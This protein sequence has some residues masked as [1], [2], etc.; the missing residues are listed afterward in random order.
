MSWQSLPL[1][2]TPTATGDTAASPE[3]WPGP[4]DWHCFDAEGR[5]YLFITNGSQVY[6]I[7]EPSF[8]RLVERGLEFLAG[9]DSLR[10]SPSPGDPRRST[11][12]RTT[13][14]AVLGGCAKVQPR[15]YIL[16]GAA[17]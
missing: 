11:G 7:D 16:L 3:S 4:T 9:P 5:S 1:L 13:A 14:L 2:A 10:H 6:E 15:L 12:F 17:G 8:D